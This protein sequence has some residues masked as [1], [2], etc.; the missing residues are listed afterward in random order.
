MTSSLPPHTEETSHSMSRRR[1]RHIHTK[2]RRVNGLCYA[3]RRN[4][5]KQSSKSA[6][7]K[8]LNSFR[9]VWRVG[10]WGY[11]VDRL[12][13]RSFE[14]APFKIHTFNGS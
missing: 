10:G 13:D 1:R 11:L 7:E 14:Q 4:K 6:V 9:F 3:K 2:P 5:K 12:I 8:D